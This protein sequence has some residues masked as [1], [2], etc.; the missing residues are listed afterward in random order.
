MVLYGLV[1]NSDG[2][3]SKRKE[4]LFKILDTWLN[5]SK[6]FLEKDFLEILFVVYCVNIVAPGVP[7]I[8]F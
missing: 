2:N 1:R 6:T 3:V 5:F 4:L 8:N 7:A